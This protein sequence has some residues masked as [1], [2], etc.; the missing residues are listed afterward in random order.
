LLDESIADFNRAI[1]L[2]PNVPGFYNNRA[3]ALRDKEL[4]SEAL[5]DYDRAIALNPMYA[6]PYCG[7]GNVFTALK[8]HGEAVAAYDKALALKPDLAE[9]WS[10]RGNVFTELKRYEEAF[11]AYDKALAL[12]PGV[13]EAWLGRGTVLSGLKRHDEAFAAYDKALA[14]KP[15]LVGVEGKRLHSSMQLCDWSNFAVALEHLV[16]SVRAGKANTEPFVFLS[17]SDSPELQ[18]QCARQWASKNCPSAPSPLWQG[19]IYRHDKIRLGYVSSDFHEHATAHLMAEAFECHDKSKFEVTAVSIGVDD[20][21]AMR[22]RLERSFARFLDWRNLGNAEIANAIRK[23]EIDLLVDLK[24]FTQDARTGIFAYRPAPIQ[25]SYLGYPAT[26]GANYIDYMIGDATIFGPAHEKFYAE[27]LVRLPHSYQPNDR[28]RA[29]SA[30][31]FTRAECELPETGF[32]FCC[33]NGNYKILPGVFDRWMRI[34]EHV[35]GSVLWLLEDHAKAAANLRKEAAMRGISP[36]RLRFAKR[37]PPAEHLARHRLA[38]LFLDT[39][40]C[41]AHTT[42][43]DALWAGLP[44]L[45]QIGETFAG[46][47]AA[48]LLN[49]VGLPELIVSS[50]EE[51][52]NVAVE[53]ANNP[54]K[55][56]EIKHRLKTNRL[57]SPLFDPQLFTRHLEAAYETMYE[58]YQAGLP[59]DHFAVAETE[60]RRSEPR[61]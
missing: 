5:G 32:V 23:A 51:Y 31:V 18:F 50:A 59:P 41:N 15:D 10:G 27:K 34:L 53:L 58:R 54:A 13:A 1:R 45:T 8:R 52:E 56:G 46:R 42:A 3:N 28:K 60:I 43:S 17:V 48:S 7:R 61:L 38:D 11:T 2:A 37:M 40:P 20:K 4:F 9:A 55:L 49:A 39:S 24:G 29:I 44:V 25:V 36:D 30:R 26:M 57:T 12:K 6:D 22:Q 47:V 19:E 33:F 14:L 35:G 16:G 21:S